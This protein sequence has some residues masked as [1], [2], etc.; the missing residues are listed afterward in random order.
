MFVFLDCMQSQIG[1]FSKQCLL[2]SHIIFSRS[3]LQT[4]ASVEKPS[5][6]PLQHPQHRPSDH[7]GTFRTYYPRPQPQQTDQRRRSKLRGALLA[8][9]LTPRQQPHQV[10]GKTCR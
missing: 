2:T 1:K 7:V 10:D 4:S 9:K 8:Q 5:D 6:H 3:H